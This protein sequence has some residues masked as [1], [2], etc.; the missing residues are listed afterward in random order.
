MPEPEVQQHVVQRRGAVLAQRVR[1]VAQRAVGDPDRQALVDPEADPELRRPQQQRDDDER[2]E[3]ERDGDPRVPERARAARQAPG[4]T[5]GVRGQASARAGGADDPLAGLGDRGE[6]G[7]AGQGGEIRRD[8]RP[9]GKAKISDSISCRCMYHATACVWKAPVYTAPQAS[10]S[11]RRRRPRSPPARCRRGRPRRRSARS[12]VELVD[13]ARPRTAPTRRRSRTASAAAATVPARCS[14][15]GP[16]TPSRRR[17]ARTRAR[18]G[19]RRSAGCRRTRPGS[20]RRRRPSA[21]CRSPPST[22]YRPVSA[23]ERDDER[24][25]A[26]DVDRQAR[27]RR[28]AVEDLDERVRG[29][30]R[31]VRV[32]LAG[33][34]GG[35][36]EVAAAEVLGQEPQD[37]QA[38]ATAADDQQRLSLRS[39][40]SR[41]RP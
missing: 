40:I 7:V 18:P 16:A 15:P 8:R 34:V 23:D 28:A 3:A 5:G 11:P 24:D 9:G 30:R 41:Y 29:E 2:G 4:G 26:A 21:R 25:A 31:R 35:S 10:A 12:R 32:G 33:A 17:R 13:V 37:D 19:A 1:D 14:W 36:E 27:H 38:Q 39:T 6:A 22:R 20:C